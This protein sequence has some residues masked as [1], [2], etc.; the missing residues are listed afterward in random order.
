[1][2][3]FEYKAVGRD[4]FEV[5]GRE[6]AESQ[7][8]LALLLRKRQLALLQAKPKRPRAVSLALVAAFVSE[9]SPLLNNGIPLERALQIVAEDTRNTKL[10]A[11]ADQLRQ[12]I[13]R[14][15][16]FSEA[17]AQSGKFDSLLI[18]LVK[19]GEASGEMAKVMAILDGY[20]QEARQVR[21]DLAASLT[22]PAMLALVSVL[23]VVAILW[24]VIPVFK[25]IFDEESQKAL[26]LGTRIVFW[27]SDFLTAHG[28]V[29]FALAALLVSAV[30]VAVN[31]VERVNRNWH[32]LQL[33][34]P[35]FGELLGQLTGFKLAKALS[36]MLLGGTPLAQAVE[37]ARPL[38][39]NRLQREGLESCLLA[40]RKGEPLPQAVARIPALP[41]QFHRYVKLGNETGNLGTS[42]SRVA[43]S[44]QSEF[45]S[46]L[47]SLVAILDPLIIILMGGAVGFMVISILLAVFNLAEV[48]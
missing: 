28:W 41:A 39:T 1:M 47:K 43:D 27:L 8:S 11:L 12:T 14:G 25:D 20:Y 21:R 6:S 3:E 45:R 5:R 36:I 16:S 48:R 19:V 2:P 18:A 46:R 40:L 34:A 33:R 29:A 13:K 42:L 24:L 23:S 10:S 17:L 15:Q 30:I 31:R 4:G 7:E 35:L 26:P 22:Y 37:I 9:L 44:L 38:L 32:A